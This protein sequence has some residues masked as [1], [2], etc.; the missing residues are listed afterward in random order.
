MPQ[1]LD[2][3]LGSIETGDVSGKMDPKRT[4]SERENSVDPKATYLYDIS[5][6]E[7]Y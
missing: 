6:G 4:G 3:H 7:K 2:F 5:N 1:I